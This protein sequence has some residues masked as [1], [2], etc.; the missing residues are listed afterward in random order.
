[1]RDNRIDISRGIAMITMIMLHSLLSYTSD[2]RVCA[3]I[4]LLGCGFD[5][6]LFF[7]VCGYFYRIEPTKIKAV[8]LFKKLLKPY[9]ACSVFLILLV[10]ITHGGFLNNVL[11]F[12]VVKGSQ[13]ICGVQWSKNIGPGPM[14][15]IISYFGASLIFSQLLK[16]G[17]IVR[18]CL[19]ILAFEVC[20]LIR[21]M[22]YGVLPF[23]FSQA[24]SALPFIYVGYELKSEFAQK[25]MFKNYVALSFGMIMVFYY[26]LGGKSLG[27]SNMHFHYNVLNIIMSIY[28][29]W[30]IYVLSSY[31][32]STSISFIGRNSL[33]I[34]LIHSIEFDLKLT[35]HITESISESM[36]IDNVFVL[37]T[38]RFSLSILFILL[39][40]MILRKNQT[41]KKLFAIP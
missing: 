14:W 40:W 6:P 28:M 25:L 29:C 11:S 36:T 9:L 15:F 16:F 26:L 13:P 35:K 21:E 4:F 23:C 31:F 30:I 8:K 10:T 12:L 2:S 27:M 17:K 32:S 24:V 41:F 7:L 3:S 37:V 38:I 39:V 5:M 18:F 22:G 34:L 19:I 20:W 33:P 1:M